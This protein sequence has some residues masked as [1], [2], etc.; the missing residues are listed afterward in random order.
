[1]SSREICLWLDERW[2]QALSR[3]LKDETLEDKL[4]GYLEEIINQLPEQVRE[5]IRNEIRTE[6]RRQEQEAE[7]AQKF[8]AF[9]VT[10]GGVTE[11]FRLKREAGL[12]EIA[13]HIRTCLRREHGP[14]PF[15]EMLRG[16]EEISAEEFDRMAAA[17][18][19]ERGKIENVYDI[20]FDKK[21]FSSVRFLTGWA[22]YKLSNVSAAVWHADHCGSHDWNVRQTRLAEKLAGKEIVSAGH[23]AAEHFSFTDEIMEDHGRLNFYME[24]CFN[25][26]K[27]FGTRTARSDDQL[28]VF[29]NY[30]MDSGQVCDELELVLVRADGR[31]ESLTYPLGAVEK[32]ALCRKMEDY[33]HQQTGQS[34]KDYSAQRMA[35]DM[36]PPAGL[37]M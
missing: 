33:C 24:N 32:T 31:E 12:L 6:Q 16:R 15:R 20:N 14:R 19:A 34:L 22:T 7:A 18:S 2:Y 13:G 26:D 11:C 17:R 25:V 28:N 9:R 23:L 29:A 37:V 35:E 27:V 1:M 5:K 21:E 10:E 8:S 3:Q 36:A 4:N 30:D